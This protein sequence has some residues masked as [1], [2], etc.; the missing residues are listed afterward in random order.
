MVAGMLHSFFFILTLQNLVWVLHLHHI[1][2][3]TSHIPS[4]QWPDV[5]SGC[6]IGQCSLVS[7]QLSGDDRWPHMHGFGPECHL[8]NHVGSLQ[9]CGKAH[10]GPPPPRPPYPH[11]SPPHLLP[12]PHFP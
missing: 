11:S 5:A 2:I 4:P 8:R 12:F 6:H 9:L 10:H 3:L 7:Y 1:V